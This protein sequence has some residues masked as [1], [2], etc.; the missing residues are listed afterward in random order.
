MSKSDCN[1][2]RPGQLDWKL[3]ARRNSLMCIM[4]TDLYVFIALYAAFHASFIY[5]FVCSSTRVSPN[6]CGVDFL[7]ACRPS[8]STRR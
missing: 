2:S 7:V 8:G 1:S 4:L 3:N 6:E 5:L